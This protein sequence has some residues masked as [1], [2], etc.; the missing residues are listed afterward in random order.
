MLSRA[1]GASTRSPL[2]TLRSEQF[3]A[4]GDATESF[5]KLTLNDCENI[6]EDYFGYY[7]EQGFDVKRPGRRL[8]LVVFRD[9]RPY[10]E[11]ARK[12]ASGVTRYTWGF[13]SKSRELAGAF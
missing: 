7:Q 13:Y 10:L 8:T 11:F 3:Q 1:F 5:M 4:V 12:F 9:E 2:V 6:A